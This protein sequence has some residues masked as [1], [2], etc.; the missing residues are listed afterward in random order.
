M[1]YWGQVA[2]GKGEHVAGGEGRKEWLSGAD[3]ESGGVQ[4]RYGGPGE[5]DWTTCSSYLKAKTMD[6]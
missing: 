5:S 1:G 3:E 4:L 2:G 6:G